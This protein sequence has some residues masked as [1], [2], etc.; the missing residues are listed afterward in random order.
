[1]ERKGRICGLFL[2]VLLVM[3][4][5]SCNIKEGDTAV[6]TPVSIYLH[7]P[8]C[9]TKSMYTVETYDVSLIVFNQE[10]LAERCMYINDGS[11]ILTFD[12]ILGKTYSFHA[13]I[14]FGHHVFADHIS[15][16][17][18]LVYHIGDTCGIP[19]QMPMYGHT[20]DILISDTK[21]I[22]IVMERLYAEIRVAMDRR[23]LS[24]DVVMK[25]TGIRIGN[26]PDRVKVMG[27]NRIRTAAECMENGHSLKNDETE[28][29]NMDSPVGTSEEISLYMLENM[30]GDIT[31]FSITDDSGKVFSEN[32]PRSSTCSYLEIDME[33]LSLKHFS[34]EGPLVYRFYLGDNRS[35][36]DIERNCIYRI[37]VTPEDDGLAED[38]W[39]VDKTY[40][41]EF[42]PSRF[43][44][45]PESYVQGNVGDTLHLWC[46]LYPPH[47]PFNIG[48]EELEYDKA[49]GIYD[50]LIDDTGHGVR[51]IL[52][53]PGTGIVYMEAGEP[54]NEIAMWIVEV[55]R[56]S[57]GTDLR[58][59]LPYMMQNMTSAVQE[60]RQRPNIPPHLLPQGQG[61]SPSL[62]PE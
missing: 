10:G 56:S 62:P 11:D 41:Q 22:H 47:A 49:L 44:Y 37:I 35:N 16:I 9:R 23:R 33:Y 45:F 51:L 25:V 40:L 43:A 46:E 53:K 1:M 4:L 12:L 54:I 32:D 38:S 26:S 60:R 17:E 21:D 20:G 29:L 31:D 50:Y 8:V 30:Q 39:R 24:D 14:N 52:K 61:R 7:S 6:E 59:T 34:H 18:E 19:S 58:D 15:E 3:G 2:T 57:D 27:P 5:H 48:L 36:L 28:P 42:G 13:F 55:N